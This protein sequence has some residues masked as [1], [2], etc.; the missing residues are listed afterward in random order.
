MEGVEKESDEELPK[1]AISG[2]AI[3]DDE[4]AVV[5]GGLS[6]TSPSLPGNLGSGRR[7]ITVGVR[8]SL[9]MVYMDA[10]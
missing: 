7:M 3:D 9:G 2:G 5:L 1:V 6:A 10:F 8:T 4:A